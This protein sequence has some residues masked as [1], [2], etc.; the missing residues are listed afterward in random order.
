MKKNLK[1]CVERIEAADAQILIDM[2]RIDVIEASGMTPDLRHK[3]SAHMSA[4]W[5]FSERTRASFRLGGG[6]LNAPVTSDA[7]AELKKLGWEDAQEKA[8]D[9]DQRA[10]WRDFP[11]RDAS[12]VYRGVQP[13]NAKKKEWLDHVF[14]DPRKVRPLKFAMDRSQKALDVSDHSPVIFDFEL[15]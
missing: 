8:P 11:Q 4:A 13:E 10:T 7:L 14:Y 6:D 15:K 3:K 12:G 1:G 2:N 9:T 5:K